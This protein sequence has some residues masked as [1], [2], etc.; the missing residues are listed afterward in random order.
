MI[1][2]L[3]VPTF[4]YRPSGLMT[5]VTV[6]IRHRDGDCFIPRV[7]QCCTSGIGMLDRGGLA[8]TC[9]SDAAD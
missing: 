8:I 3:P 9:L 6:Q 1:S 5:A 2:S 7:D 4:C